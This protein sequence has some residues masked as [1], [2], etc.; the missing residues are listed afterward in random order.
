L[1]LGWLSFSCAKLAFCSIGFLQGWLWFW[2][3]FGFVFCWVG[4]GLSWVSFGLG[5]CFELGWLGPVW[6]WAGLAFCWVGFN[7]LIAGLAFG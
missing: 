3:A 5:H 6:L 2:A 7:L 1:I 4:F